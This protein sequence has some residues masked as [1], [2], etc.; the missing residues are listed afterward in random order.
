MSEEYLRSAPP[1]PSRGR[2]PFWRGA[3]GALRLAAWSIAGVFGAALALIPIALE[4]GP[5]GRV[6]VR[7]AMPE[8]APR[9]LVP[10]AAPDEELPAAR[11]AGEAFPS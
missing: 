6:R 3:A 11:A 1:R 10:D 8:A 5:R 2:P 7:D 9:V 4:D